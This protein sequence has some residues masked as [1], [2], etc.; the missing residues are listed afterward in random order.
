M[1]DRK[2]PELSRKSALEEGRSRLADN[3]CH[4][5]REKSSLSDGKKS[6][7]V[8]VEGPRGNSCPTLHSTT[9]TPRS[10]GVPCLPQKGKMRNRQ[11]LGAF[12]QEAPRENES[13]G[14]ARSEKDLTGRAFYR[15]DETPQTVKWL[16]LRSLEQKEVS[17]DVSGGEFSIL[18]KT[19]TVLSASSGNRDIVYRK[20][21]TR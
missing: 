16:G 13:S 12:T 8:L 11:G 18:G 3:D 7:G 2:V 14:S 17:G 6:C 1:A 10:M 15:N 4:R 21:N 5:D 20:N 19:H 9:S